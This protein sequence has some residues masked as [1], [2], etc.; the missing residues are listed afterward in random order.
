MAI[1]RA[2]TQLNMFNP[3]VWY[4]DIIHAD[5]N[6]IHISDG[7]NTAVYI[8]HGF[9][10][11][12]D[13]VVA[14]TLTGYQQYSGGYLVGEITGLNLYAPSVSAY[15]DSNNLNALLELGLR[16]DD[17]IYGSP[18]DD[19]IEGYGGNDYIDGGAGNDVIYGGAGNDVIRGGPGENYIDGGEGFDYAVYDGFGSSY[20]YWVNLETAE[21]QVWTPDLHVND[22][23]V[24]IERLAFDDGM[25]A[26]DIEGNAGR[27]YRIYEAA[28]DRTP[29]TPGLS[30]WV[31][32]L[33][34]G[35]SL[36]ALAESFIHSEEFRDLYGAQTSDRELVNL[37]YENVLDRGA[38][39]GGYAYW[40]GQMDAGMSRSD[41][42]IAFS[43]SIENKMNVIGDIEY[44]IWLV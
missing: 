35:A 21:I 34:Q 7:F 26:F 5:A 18:E 13:D 36:G 43:E 30:Y 24:S 28:F 4:G 19:W 17:Q 42:L 10:Y 29:D 22:W 8:G 9:S 15:L 37:L 23:L 16:G 2:Y 27:G 39:E 33:D 44:G 12:W 11:G 3:A 31:D 25:L 14:G 41:L 32:V 6:E 1:V 20:S 40:T 38:D